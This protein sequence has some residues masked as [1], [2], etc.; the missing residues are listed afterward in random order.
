MR[1]SVLAFLWLLLLPLPA[2]AAEQIDAL[3]WGVRV[4]AVQ[5]NYRSADF[6]TAGGA[7]ALYRH[8][9][10]PFLA[11]ELEAMATL[12]DG[13][14]VGRDFSI[15][16]VGAYLAWRSRGQWYLKLRGGILAEYVEVGEADAWGSGLAGGIGAGFRRGEQLFEIELTGVEQAA[17][18]VSLAWYF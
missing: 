13:E 7:S 14:L 3:N 15:S 6:A 1:G 12:I 9:E 4:G 17:Y 5:P 8:R 11:L 18:M 16:T 10:Y 2:A